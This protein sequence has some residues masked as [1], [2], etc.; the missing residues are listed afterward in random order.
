MGNKMGCKCNTTLENL[1][2]GNVQQYTVTFETNSDSTTIE[3]QKVLSGEKVV[4]P[5]VPVKAGF[6]FGGWYK[7]EELNK[8]WNFNTDVITE[9]KILYAKWLKNLHTVTFHFD[10]YITT[11][12]VPDGALLNKPSIPI[13]EGHKFLVGLTKSARQNGILKDL[14]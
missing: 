10:T 6:T 1:C 12:E 3:E 5:D 14:G 7:D 13:K 8:P 9:N 2:Q 11:V 4:E